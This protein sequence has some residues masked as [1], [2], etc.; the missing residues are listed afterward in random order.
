LKLDQ[1]VE[2]SSLYIKQKHLLKNSKFCHM[3]KSNKKRCWNLINISIISFLP[4][5]LNYVEKWELVIGLFFC[6][7]WKKKKKCFATSLTTQFSS[8]IW[9]FQL[10]VFIHHGC[11]RTSWQ[12]CK[13]CNSS[14]IWCN[15]LKFNYNFFTTT[16]FQLLCNSPMTT[17]VMSCWRHFNPSI[18]I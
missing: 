16:H 17:I 1:H 18:K 14:F 6:S 4:T 5:Q 13:N 10:I 7:L 12:N 9:H 8:C 15:S 11:Y 2:F 3:V